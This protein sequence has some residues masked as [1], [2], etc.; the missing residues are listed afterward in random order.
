MIKLGLVLAGCALGLCACQSSSSETPA[1]S[2]GVRETV[3]TAPADL[4]LLCASE[5]QSRL[6]ATGDVL[7]ISSSQTSAGRYTVVLSVG[8]G[9]A[10][11]VVTDQGVV[12]SVA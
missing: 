9:E 1:A 8:G 10:S 6:G 7:P 11:C 2:S 12:E 3:V 5:A 4:Q